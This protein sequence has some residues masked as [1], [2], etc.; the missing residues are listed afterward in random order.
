MTSYPP[1]EYIYGPYEFD[2]DISRTREDLVSLY[3]KW[4][5]ITLETLAQSYGL[6]SAE[7]GL[8][9]NPIRMSISESPAISIDQGANSVPLINFNKP[10]AIDST[11]DSSN[12]AAEE[13]AYPYTLKQE[14]RI[15]R[16]VDRLKLIHQIISYHGVGGCY[17]DPY[18]LKKD[19]CLL[20]YSPLHDMVEL[21]DLEAEW[22]TF[23]DWPWNQPVDKVK[24][25]FGEKIGLYFKWLGLYTTWLMPAAVLGLCVWINIATDGKLLSL[26]SSPP[27][28][29]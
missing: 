15:F 10:V 2:S 12:N 1:Y 13:V 26:F 4:P 19:E 18:R 23:L 9:S 25:Y 21:R 17:L 14:A 29:F 28:V 16:G 20:A 6:S 24:D 5:L 7:L 8:T 11:T 22:L 27:S 3:K